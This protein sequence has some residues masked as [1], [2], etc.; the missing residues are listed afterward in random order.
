MRTPQKKH[1]GRYFWVWLSAAMLL[2]AWLR[3]DQFLDQTLID[4]EWHAVHQVMLSSPSRFM[5]SFGHA[6]Y[7]IPLTLLYWLQA[8]WFGLSELGMRLPM[9]IAGLAT[10]VLFPLALRRELGDRIVL[11]F[12][13]MLACSPLL[14]A[15]SRMARPYA[16]TLLFSFCAY[17]FLAR[18]LNDGKLRWNLAIGYVILSTLA[19]WLHPITGPFLVTPLI[20]LWWNWLRERN[21]SLSLRS[22]LML[23]AATG[24]MMAIALLPPLLSDPAALAGKSGVDSLTAKTLIGIW[25]AWLGTGNTAVVIVALCLALFGVPPVWRTSQIVRWALAGLGLTM[26]AIVITRP[27]WIF[28][29]LTFAR[30]L[31]PALPILLLLIAAGFFRLLNNR[32]PQVLTVAFGLAVLAGLSLTS[33]LPDQLRFPN[34]NTLHLETQMDYRASENSF[35]PFIRKFPLSPFWASLSSAPAGSITVAVAPFRFESFDWPAPVWESVSKQRVIPAFLSG[36]CEPWLY[37]NTPHDARFR[38]R[39][40]A[41]VGDADSLR[42]ARVTYLAFFKAARS[43]LESK[44]KPYLPQCETWMRNHY[45][46]PHFDDASLVVWKVDAQ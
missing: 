22:L 21:N 27:A 37:G 7:S 23:S 28:H 43:T 2:G 25:Y 42:R 9:M 20:A 13:F 45:G 14:I 31:L 35:I 32:L 16:L 8:Q 4:D 11:T 40:A 26:L 33:P 36:T 17:A 12:A 3:L 30:Y 41:H 10:V 1:L 34:S 5:L 46:T 24:V 19:L 44:D 29:S 15:F 39:S 38:F 6:D 18:A